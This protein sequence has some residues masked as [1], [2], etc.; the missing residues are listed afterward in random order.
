[1]GPFRARK[2]S[3]NSHLTQKT[4]TRVS[5]PRKSQITS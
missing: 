2:L 5:N 4:P 1:L 3:R